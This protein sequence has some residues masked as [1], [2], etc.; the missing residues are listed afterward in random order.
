MNGRG[1]SISSKEHPAVIGIPE[2]FQDIARLN[3]AERRKEYNASEYWMRGEP[4]P[5]SSAMD[6]L[7]EES[8]RELMGWVLFGRDYSTADGEP[9]EELGKY[10]RGAI[11]EPRNLQTGYLE[12]KP[13]GE[14]LRQAVDH[15]TGFPEREQSLVDGD[16]YAN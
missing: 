3:D 12:A 10:I 7:S 9:G 13:I 2:E 8:F 1:R 4:S 11:T 5:L 15:L 6:A 14:Y 16:D